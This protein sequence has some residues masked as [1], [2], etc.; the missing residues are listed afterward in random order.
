[1]S[2]EIDFWRE[3]SS[4]LA[5]QLAETDKSYNSKIEYVLAEQENLSE[6]QQQVLREL[7]AALA[8]HQAQAA[9]ASAAVVASTPAAAGDG[10]PGS[11]PGS[12]GEKSI[13]S[14]DQVKDLVQ[15]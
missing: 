10:S 4:T 12:A 7:S 11:N 8:A 15:I 2:K 3:R 9:A 13:F 5:S 1:M 14:P 6:K